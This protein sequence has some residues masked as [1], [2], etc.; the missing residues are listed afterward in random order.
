MHSSHRGSAA[1]TIVLLLIACGCAS[2]PAPHTA[3]APQPDKVAPPKGA[4]ESEIP[5][6]DL[7]TGFT[8]IVSGSGD[9]VGA[10]PGSVLSQ[11]AYR[12]RQIDPGSDRFTYQ[13]RDL[14][15]YFRPTPN[16]L[17]FQVENR[18]NHIVTIDWDRSTW[19]GP[20][21]SEK[22]AHNPTRW[23]DRYGTQSPTQILGLQRYSDYMFPISYLV[24]PGSTGQQLHRVLFPEDQ[25]AI[26]YTD[27][28]FGVDFSFNIDNRTV[29][30]SFRFKVASVVPR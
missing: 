20:N 3:A 12:F 13:D 9:S 11:Y 27:Q 30:Y 29:P 24:D 4:V 1:V 5:G 18:L 19:V 23:S 22:I 14:S 16:A 10:I 8:R 6:P 26:Q 2:N 28:V 21:G 7:H 15:F 25:S 17:H